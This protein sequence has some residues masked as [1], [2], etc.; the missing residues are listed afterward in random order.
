M[1]LKTLIGG[2]L[3]SVAP[4]SWSQYERR[5]VRG[6]ATVVVPITIWQAW[7]FVRRLRGRGEG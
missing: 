2:M 3:L 7:L 1:R 5:A 6:F 4:T